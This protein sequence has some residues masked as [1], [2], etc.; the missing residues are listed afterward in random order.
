MTVTVA[1]EIAGL[2]LWPSSITMALMLFLLPFAPLR[3]FRRAFRPRSRPLYLLVIVLAGSAALVVLS[4]CGSNGY[5]G[6][7][8]RNYT[9]TVTAASGALA[10]TT[11]LQLNVQ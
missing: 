5:L 7:A 2:H 10:H 8:S 11:T 1:K 6:Q 3:R 4:G 9:L